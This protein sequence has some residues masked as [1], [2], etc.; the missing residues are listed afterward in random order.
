MHYI[1]EANRQQLSLL[2]ESLEDYVAANNPVRV[3]DR[4]VETLDLAVLGFS[5][6]VLKKTGRPPYSPAALLKLYIYGYLNQVRSSRQ[7]ERQTHCNVE[8]MWLLGRLQPDFKTIADFRKDNRKALRQVVK[9]F[10]QVC[11]DLNL[12]GRELVAIDGSFFKAS[13]SRSRHISQKSLDKNLRALDKQ[14]NKYLTSLDRR[15]KDDDGESLMDDQLAEKLAR[16]EALQR[17]KKEQRESLKA[18]GET[19]RALTDA[20]A[21]LLKKG[22]QQMIGYN[23]QAAVDSKYHLI[24]SHEVTNAGNDQGQLAPMAKDSREALEAE[25]MEV[26]ADSGYHSRAG[27][28]ACEEQGVSTYVAPMNSSSSKARNRYSKADFDYD[29]ER[30]VYIC[31]AKEEMGFVGTGRDKTGHRLRYYQA[32]GCAQCPLRSQCLKPGVAYRRISRW[33]NEEIVEANRARIQA[34]PDKM[35]RRMG[36][37][38][39]PFGTIK[40]WC[41]SQHFLTRGFSNV[42][43]EMS[44][45]VL[46]YNLKRTMNVLG[47][48]RL[49]E[50]L[51]KRSPVPAS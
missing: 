5:R 26:L 33:E 36:L 28:K 2:P 48:E 38:E 12:Y 20:D 39:H 14:I 13:N 22:G 46:A 10:R 43:T 1:Q 47:V 7:L 31:P 44:L 17:E 45:N 41:G 49:L 18:A 19:Q 23:V 21:K 27:L 34:H 37:A 8:V 11:R 32:K 4:F 51:A 25:R 30:D 16:L 40:Q 50:E 29:A 35:K 3:I 15:D 24:A 6:A 9:E 42:K